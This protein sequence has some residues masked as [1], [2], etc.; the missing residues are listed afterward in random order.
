[1]ARLPQPGS[2]EGNW[3]TILNDFL[4]VSH[5][6]DGTLKGAAVPA[7][8]STQRVA[9]SKDGT[10]V[11]TRPQVNFVTGANT[12]LTVADNAANNRVDVTIAA[13]ASGGADPAAAML[14]FAAQ[15]MQ[16][17]QA[18]NQFIVNTGICV[19]MLVRVPS[20]TI[21]TLGAWKVSEGSGPTGTCGMALYTE[22]GVLIDQT[23]SMAA[24]LTS[25]GNA[26]VS[27]TLSG[28]ARAVTAGNYYVALLSNMTTGP[29]MAAVALTNNAPAIN[30]HYPSVY[31]T[32][33]S[34]FPA[35][36]NPATAT[37]N[38]GIFYFAIY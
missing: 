6:G 2:D 19:F 36:F 13:S 11:G 10:V 17:S 27:G 28:G 1:M 9:V 31:L 20:T 25:P 24:A 22:A 3:G 37:K 21:N 5:N 4:A 15:T 29:Q 30:G 35:S 8:T 32:G 38:N 12:T 7:D 16:L 34:G 14:G 18:E 23:A 26:W 33:Q